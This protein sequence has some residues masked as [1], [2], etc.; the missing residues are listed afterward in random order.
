MEYALASNPTSR[1]RAVDDIFE[2]FRFI[3]KQRRQWLV[4]VVPEAEKSSDYKCLAS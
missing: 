3:R 4:T 1:S 2:L